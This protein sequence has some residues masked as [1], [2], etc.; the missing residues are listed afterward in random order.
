LTKEIARLIEAG[1]ER[2]VGTFN[3]HESSAPFP[4]DLDIRTMKFRDEEYD[5]AFGKND[6]VEVIM[7][8]YLI[9]FEKATAKEIGKIPLTYSAFYDQ[10]L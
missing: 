4:S 2:K 5:A 10:E 3:S 1:Q 8:E 9:V 7:S 6:L